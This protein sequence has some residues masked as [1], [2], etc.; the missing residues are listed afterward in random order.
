MEVLPHCGWDHSWADGPECC[1]KAGWVSQ[2]KQA[3]K[4]YSMASASAPASRFLFGSSSCLNFP[5]SCDSQYVSHINPPLLK[6]LWATWCFMTAIINLRQKLVPGLQKI[7][8]DLLYRVVMGEDWGRTLGLWAGKTIECSKVGKLLW[9]VGRL[10]WSVKSSKDNGG[11]TCELSE[12]S[13]DS[14][15]A[16]WWFELRIGGSGQLGLKTRLSL[17]TEAKTLFYWC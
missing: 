5:L 2:E 1:K 3:S 8:C 11:L 13:K 15:I 16:A 4:Q 7:A 12:R 14:I 10:E 17:I 9:E 6:L